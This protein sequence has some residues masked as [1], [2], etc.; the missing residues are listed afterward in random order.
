VRQVE[1]RLDLA[2]F[3]FLCVTAENWTSSDAFYLGFV[4]QATAVIDNR[5][6]RLIIWPSRTLITN[7]SIKHPHP[8]PRHG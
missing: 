3:H 8:S 7:G 1:D 4:R 2:G 6:R 5:Q